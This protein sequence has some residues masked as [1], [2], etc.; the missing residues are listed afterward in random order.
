MAR[1]E[2]RK[3]QHDKNFYDMLGFSPKSQEPYFIATVFCDSLGD[4]GL[5][6]YEG[7]LGKGKYRD[8]VEAEIV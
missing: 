5:D 4:M 8:V 7:E 3:N 2:F 1:I 6:N